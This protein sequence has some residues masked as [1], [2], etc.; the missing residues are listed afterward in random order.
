MA[1]IGRG[2]GL[3][4]RVDHRHDNAQH[5]LVQQ[6]ADKRVVIAGDAGHWNRGTSVDGNERSN[7]AVFTPRAMLTVDHDKVDAAAAQKFSV[8]RRTHCQAEPESGLTGEHLLF[9]SVENHVVP[10][11]LA[12]LKAVNRSRNWS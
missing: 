9:C 7:G 8:E 6:A 5:A 1:G 3:V 11:G 2:A 10:P 4:R 12:D